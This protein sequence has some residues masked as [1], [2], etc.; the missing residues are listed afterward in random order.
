ME[1]RK[2]SSWAFKSVKTEKYL[3]KGDLLIV[4]IKYLY[5]YRV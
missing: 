2:F 4:L 3:S 1:E 5:A